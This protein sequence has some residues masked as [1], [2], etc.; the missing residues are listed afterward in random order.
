MFSASSPNRLRG[1]D[2]S[3]FLGLKY[4]RQKYLSGDKGLKYDLLRHPYL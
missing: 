2:N 3:R 1:F 4:E